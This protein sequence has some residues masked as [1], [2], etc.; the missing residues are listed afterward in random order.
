MVR[1]RS[2]V[3]PLGLEVF[4]LPHRD[5]ESTSITPKAYRI[6]SS[7]PIVAYNSIR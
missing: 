6:Q 3:P 4:Y 7:I 5:I 1:P 2:T